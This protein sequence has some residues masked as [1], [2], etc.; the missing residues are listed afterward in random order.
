ERWIGG[1]L[2]SILSSF[3]GG[4]VLIP[5]RYNIRS[6]LVRRTTS[7]MTALGVALVVMILVILLG[8]IAGLRYTV[9]S[10]AG[11]DNWIVLA[12]GVTSEPGSYIAR[13]QYQIIRT[14]PE[15][16]TA[17]SG[18]ALVSPEIVTGFD[19]AP[20]EPPSAG[21]S[22]FLRGVYPIA[23]AVHR[24]MRIASGRWPARG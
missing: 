20:D 2:L 22:T 24:E 4:G 16:A 6:L 7:V 14:R 15:V 1:E 23:Y 18:E 21:R 12:R 8:F 9:L 5:V 3:P 10:A 19:P 17:P 11:R 13:E